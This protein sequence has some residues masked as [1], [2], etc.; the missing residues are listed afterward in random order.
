ME[1]VE[2]GPVNHLMSLYT[3]RGFVQ[4]GL[5]FDFQHE[6]EVKD[7][8]TFSDGKPGKLIWPRLT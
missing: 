5:G 1:L 4:Q 8:L 3:L 6:P 2:S 7:W